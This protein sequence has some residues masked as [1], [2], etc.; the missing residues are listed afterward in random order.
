MT[1]LKVTVTKILHRADDEYSRIKKTWLTLAHKTNINLIRKVQKGTICLTFFIPKD[2]KNIYD[3]CNL[4]NIK[5]RKKY[6]WWEEKSLITNRQKR[7]KSKKNSRVWVRLFNRYFILKSMM[8][9]FLKNNYS[10][11]LYFWI[12]KDFL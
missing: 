12:S 6:V 9:S 10:K 11:F 8:K 3:T 2:R 1:K 4:N 7:K 5:E